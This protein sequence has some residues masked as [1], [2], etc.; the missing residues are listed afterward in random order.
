LALAFGKEDIVLKSLLLMTSLVSASAWALPPDAVQLNE[1]RE[2]LKAI[3]AHLQAPVDGRSCEL[4]PASGKLKVADL[5]FNY[6]LWS[7]Q[8]NREGVEKRPALACGESQDAAGYRECYLTAAE[9]IQL[10]G[11]PEGWSRTLLFK[12]NKQKKKVSAASF[13]CVD[14]P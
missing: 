11:E 12:F 10:P 13:R 9:K 7:L 6:T 8:K 2:M 3:F 14:V 4:K 5:V 1:D